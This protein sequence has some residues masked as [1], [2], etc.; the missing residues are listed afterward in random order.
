MTT[1][2]AAIRCRDVTKRFVLDVSGALWKLLRADT[3]AP[4]FVALDGINI[5]VPAG[6]FVGLL[7][8]NGAGKSTLLRTIGGIYAADRGTIRVN[9]KLTGLYE[10]GIGGNDH[11]NGTQFARR[12]FDIVGV[13]GR[14]IGEL[15]DEIRDFSELEAAFDRP[16][17]TYSSG[18]R[19]RLYFAVATALPA[20]VYIID[21]MLSVGDEYFQNKCWR[22]LRDRLNR[23]GAS[24]VL[25]THDWTAI[26]K[27]CPTCH[28]LEGGRI[29][30]GGRSPDV[31]RDYLGNK[32][33]DLADGAK[34]SSALPARVAAR[35]LDD[36]RMDIPIEV[37]DPGTVQFGASIERFL[38]GYGW[39]HVIHRSPGSILDK[40]GYHTIELAIPNLPLPAATYSLCLFL[41][42]LSPDGGRL[43]T[44][45]RSWTHG[46]ALA[47]E[48]D[49]AR[50]RGAMRLQLSIARATRH[51]AVA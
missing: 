17:R 37:S 19:A 51:Q 45:V 18:M 39:E 10:L 14:K 6:E 34:F 7:G 5:D 12:W 40:P 42:M 4:S 44:D 23:G 30:S 20:E 49:G 9:G 29:V 24:G 47:L 16:L 11:L 28:I 1:E 35:S 22:R 8:R 27:L 38:P 41:T 48:V 33:T 43:I 46:N 15:I 3:R 31:V 26:L 25:A 50:S 2:P 21:E 13:G 32:A 36:F